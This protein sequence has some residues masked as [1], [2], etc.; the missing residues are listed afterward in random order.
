MAMGIESFFVCN[1]LVLWWL[2]KL[3]KN[4]N[5]SSR[6][7]VAPVEAQGEHAQEEFA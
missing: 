4:E 7:G 3:Q 5:R 6:T 2:G 1:L